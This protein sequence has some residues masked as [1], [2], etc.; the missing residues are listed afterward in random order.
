MNCNRVNVRSSAPMPIPADEVRRNKLIACPVS[1]V[2]R[3]SNDR[4]LWLGNPQGSPEAK[5]A[6][7]WLRPDLRQRSPG[8]GVFRDAMQIRVCAQDI[9]SVLSTE[10]GSRSC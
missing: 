1:W 2:T 5:P 10:E 4:T 6:T 3:N 7:Y 9:D 8:W